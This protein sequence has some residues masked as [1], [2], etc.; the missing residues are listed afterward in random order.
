MAQRIRGGT[1]RWPEPFTPESLAADL[2]REFRLQVE[3]MDTVEAFTVRY[4]DFCLDPQV[5]ERLKAFVDSPLTGSGSI[6]L[7]N[8]NNPRRQAEVEV[9][10]SDVGA[11]QVARWQREADP[12]LRDAAQA[13]FDLMG[14]YA[15]RWEYAR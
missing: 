2:N 7:F 4:E 6:G 1:A 9:H 11:E 5:Y 3:L 10:G 12:A 13:T 15:E 14:E 8:A